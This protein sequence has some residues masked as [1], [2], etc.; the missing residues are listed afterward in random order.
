[1]LSLDEFR[2]IMRVDDVK[3]VRELKLE[4][5]FN[6]VRVADNDYVGFKNNDPFYAYKLYQR[7]FKLERVLCGK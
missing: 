2:T 5:Y 4:K 3:K 6:I 7:K 1:M